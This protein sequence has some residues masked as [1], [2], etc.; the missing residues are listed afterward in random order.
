MYNLYFAKKNGVKPKTQSTPQ[1]KP[2]QQSR[3]SSFAQPQTQQTAQQPQSFSSSSG[4][5]KGSVQPNYLAVL[6]LSSP[7]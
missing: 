2:E 5:T 3:R 4:G 7:K 6:Q 1:L